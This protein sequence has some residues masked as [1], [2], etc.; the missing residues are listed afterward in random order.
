MQSIS[1]KSALRQT[2]LMTIDGATPVYT[3]MM[4][5]LALYTYFYSHNV[6]WSQF[7][8]LGACAVFVA[9]WTWVYY[10][11]RRCTKTHRLLTDDEIHARE[12]RGERTW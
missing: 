11:S 3:A 12:L 4:L 10:H 7:D 6:F 5:V 9:M 1:W 2:L 8:V